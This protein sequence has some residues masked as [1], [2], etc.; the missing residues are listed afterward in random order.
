MHAAPL[1][2]Q[3]PLPEVWQL[4]ELSQQ[5]EQDVESQTHL[6]PVLQCCPGEH[7]PHVAPLIPHSPAASLA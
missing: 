1:T 6:P 2:P 7:D 4:P 3:V 5:P